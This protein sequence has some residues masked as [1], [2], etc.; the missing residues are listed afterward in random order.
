[1]GLKA[2]GVAVFP[3]AFMTRAQ[4]FA[5][6]RSCGGSLL[7]GL[8]GEMISSRVRLSSHCGVRSFLL[9]GNA[10]FLYLSCWASA[11]RLQEPR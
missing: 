4:M 5:A 3:P 6:T 9:G 11:D 2:L 8:Y 10:A 1:M 7:V